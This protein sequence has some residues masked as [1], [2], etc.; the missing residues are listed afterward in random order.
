MKNMTIANIL[1]DQRTEAINLAVIPFSGEFYDRNS[2]INY[3]LPVLLSG[4]ARRDVFKQK[5]V[6][7]ACTVVG[8]GRSFLF[9][10]ESIEFSA[11]DILRLT[12]LKMLFSA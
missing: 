3:T 9:S 12:R 7:Q 10:V 1:L 8:L 2:T 4:F 6:H 11:S 5:I